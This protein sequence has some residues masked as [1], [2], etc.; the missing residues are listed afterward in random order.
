MGRRQEDMGLALFEEMI[1]R[2][3]V[4]RSIARDLAWDGTICSST[5]T[6]TC[7]GRPCNILG[8]LMVRVG[9]PLRDLT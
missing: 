6:C 4:R 7:I 2:Y 1:C 8:Y 5:C 9:R 3:L